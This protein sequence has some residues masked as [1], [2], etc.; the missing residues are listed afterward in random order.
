MYK[1]G[2]RIVYGQAGVMTVVDIREETVLNERKT[3]YVLRAFD[4]GEGALTFVPTDNGELVSL[5]RPLMKKE[6]IEKMLSAVKSF[7]DFQ[8]IEDSRARS[9]AFKKIVDTDDIPELLRMIMA[10]EEKIAM[11]TESGKR[12]YLSDEVIMKKAKKRLYS[13]FSAV[14][15]LSYEQTENYVSYMLKQK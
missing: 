14:L 5:M 15:G 10:I 11:R 9:L 8:W 13:E 3:Y 12:S 7:P 6:E 1:V 2:D 4:A